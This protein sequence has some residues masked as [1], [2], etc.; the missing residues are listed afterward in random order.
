MIISK[1]RSYRRHHQRRMKQK[2]RRVFAHSMSG[3]WQTAEDREQF[4]QR[5]EHLA[6]HLAYCSRPCCNKRRKW[7]GLPIQERRFY[8]GESHE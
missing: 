1:G 7:D 2:A 8:Q 4:L 5:C 6:N 3:V